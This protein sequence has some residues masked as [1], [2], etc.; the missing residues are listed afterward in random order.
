[1]DAKNQF[2]Y[3]SICIAVGFL[4][5]V[6]YEVFSFFRLIFGCKRGK[7]RILG[8]IFDVSFCLIFGI[9]AVF[10]SYLLHFPDFRGY[11]WFGYG[12]GGIIYFKFLHKIIAFFENLCY[13]KLS[14]WIKRALN[15]K[16]TL[17][18]E[19]DKSL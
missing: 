18:K 7:N 1:M 9:F 2:A 17:S 4:G 15:K 13:N 6:L 16:K 14:K 10:S 12:L 3:F 19:V 8:G 11:M 5:G